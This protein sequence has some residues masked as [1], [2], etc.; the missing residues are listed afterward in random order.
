LHLRG[1]WDKIYIYLNQS[2]ERKLFALETIYTIPVNKTFETAEDCPFC[3]L[4]KELEKNELDIIL[5][6]SMM[7]PDIRIQTNKLGFCKSHYEQMF[8]AKNRLGLALILESHLDSV[9]KVL[10]PGAIGLKDR[11]ERIAE[12]AK[13]LNSTCYICN[14]VEHHFA[15]MIE[16]SLILWERDKE[17]RKKFDSQQYFCVPHY[18]RLMES[19]KKFLPKKL[20]GD[21]VASA[22]RIQDAYQEKLR[23]DVSWFVKKFDYRYKDEPWGDS[24][25]AVERAIAF[26]SGK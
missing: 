25:D 7:E 9:D 3:R 13:E 18:Q 21:F 12:G 19:A 5:G 1:K 15:K 24:K 22:E 11:S 6:A 8:T 26:L 17:F 2:K 16:T 4:F 23:E 14:R 20:L 10:S